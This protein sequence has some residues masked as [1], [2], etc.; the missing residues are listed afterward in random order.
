MPAKALDHCRTVRLR[1]DMIVETKL[2]F[3]R[4]KATGHCSTVHGKF[5]ILLDI[6]VSTTSADTLASKGTLNL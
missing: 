6:L 3:K 5:L 4:V 1:V 2:A